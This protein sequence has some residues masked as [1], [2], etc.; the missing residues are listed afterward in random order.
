MTIIEQEQTTIKRLDDFFSGRRASGNMHIADIKLDNHNA[1]NFDLPDNKLGLAELKA[2]IAQ[3]GV[4]VPVLVRFD[5]QTKTAYLVD[6][7]RRFRAVKEL[8]D[9][10]HD[11]EILIPVIRTEATTPVEVLE[12]SV[13]ANIGKPFE[14]WEL[15]TAYRKFI[16]FGWNNAMIAERF[17]KTERF[18]H[19]AIELSQAPKD[20]L[21]ALSKQEITPMAA[22]RALKH[23]D[24]KATETVKQ[25]VEA[26]KAKGSKGPAKAT[27][28]KRNQF[29]KVPVKLAYDLVRT[30]NKYDDT[31]LIRFHAQLEA[32]LP[33]K[34][35]VRGKA[36]KDLDTF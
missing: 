18:V 2:D 36:A 31:D 29:V 3:N 11:P 5:K 13:S 20:V 32:L 24:E 21:I 7:E 12:Q 4:L 8:N 26:A 33:E 17:G 23:G 6:G 34:A 19:D 22:L 16:K 9:E 27:Y 28:Q 14:P 15:G 35:A 1:R 30:L 25:V 10:G